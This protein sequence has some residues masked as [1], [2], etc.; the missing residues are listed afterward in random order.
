MFPCVVCAS[1]SWSQSAEISFAVWKFIFIY[2]T[3]VN[4]AVA[5]STDCIRWM[6]KSGWIAIEGGRTEYWLGVL[7]IVCS[8]DRYSLPTE[9]CA[10]VSNWPK[11]SFARPTF[12]CPAMAYCMYRIIW[13]T[14][15]KCTVSFRHNLTCVGLLSLN[16]VITFFTLRYG[17]TI[18]VVLW[19][20]VFVVS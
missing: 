2:I 12:T 1:E 13:S 15:S 17:K 4:P 11:V 8:S 7:L 6:T 10:V 3:Y 20:L 5:L 16:T 18:A 9:S 19:V 14:V